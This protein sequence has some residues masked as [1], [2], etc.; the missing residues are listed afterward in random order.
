[1]PH[2]ATGVQNLVKRQISEGKAG[3]T[4]CEVEDRHRRHHHPWSTGVHR[5]QETAPPLGPPHDPRYSP[6]V[7]SSAGD[8]SYE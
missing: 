2:A 5:S 4:A 1:M 3:M 8:V 6:A 7:G